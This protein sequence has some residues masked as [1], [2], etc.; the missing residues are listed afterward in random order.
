MWIGKLPEVILPPNIE[1]PDF[2]DL[3]YDPRFSIA[4]MKPKTPSNL[5]RWP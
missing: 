1:A 3:R 5:Q 2:D 4:K